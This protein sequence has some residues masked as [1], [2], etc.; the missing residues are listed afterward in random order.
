MIED[1]WHITPLT[2]HAPPCCLCIVPDPVRSIQ[3]TLIAMSTFAWC[4]I[5]HFN[6]AAQIFEYDL[7]MHTG[8][9]TEA[10]FSDYYMMLADHQMCRLDT[11]ESCIHKISVF[12][13]EMLLGTEGL[14]ECP[15]CHMI[16]THKMPKCSQCW[17]RYCS[18]ECQKKDWKKGHK[19]MCEALTQLREAKF[20]T[21]RKLNR[22]RKCIQQG[23]R[24][25]KGWQIVNE[26]T[27]RRICQIVGQRPAG[28]DQSSS[29]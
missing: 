24:T 3:Q 16:A 26:E 2:P 4:A 12:E 25:G 9:F 27:F 21:S 29:Q 6:G 23:S 14:W 20:T 1:R 11:T 13:F 18:G 8:S 22:Y 19:Q 7:I 28:E 10:D 17:V 15:A 5:P